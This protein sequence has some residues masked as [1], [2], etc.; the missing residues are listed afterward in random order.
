MVEDPSR[1]RHFAGF[2]H[3]VAEKFDIGV[4]GV[5]LY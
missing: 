2:A 4:H 3:R 5:S 1:V